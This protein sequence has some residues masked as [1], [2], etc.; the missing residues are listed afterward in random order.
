MCSHG[1]R[2]LVDDKSV[3]SCRRTCSRLLSTGVLHFVLTTRNKSANNKLQLDEIEKF[4]AISSQ[5]RK[6]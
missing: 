1:L 3:P 4:V 2:Q 5:G 6:K